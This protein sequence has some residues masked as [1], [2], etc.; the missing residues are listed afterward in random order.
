M[1]WGRVRYWGVGWFIRGYHFCIYGAINKKLYGSWNLHSDSSRIFSLFY[2]VTFAR[3][4]R[5]WN[6]FFCLADCS[7]DCTFTELFW[8]HF[9][10][11]SKSCM[12]VCVCFQWLGEVTFYL[13]LYWEL[14]QHANLQKKHVHLIMLEMTIFW[15]GHQ[16]YLWSILF[17]M[18]Y[19]ETAHIH[20]ERA[21]CRS[22]TVYWGAWPTICSCMGIQIVMNIPDTNKN[23]GGLPFAKLT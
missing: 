11:A 18:V 14:T 8:G 6:V 21:T 10:F 5:T 16:C 22:L 7:T 23:N 1:F 13:I 17:H 9:L 2:C 4:N 15:S 12:C 3:I 19:L 20:L